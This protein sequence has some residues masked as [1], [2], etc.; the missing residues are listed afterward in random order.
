MKVERA[1]GDTIVS[2]PT[3]LVA[4][5]RVAAQYTI[6]LKLYLLIL[7]A[8]LI[9]AGSALA[10]ETLTVVDGKG[11][12]LILRGDQWADLA[13]GE[14]VPEGVPI[15]TLHGA[16]ITLSHAGQLLTL[17]PDSAARLD[18]GSRRSTVLTQFAGTLTI[19]A[20]LPRGNQLLVRAPS[21]TVDV[22]PGAARLV[23]IADPGKVEVAAGSAIVAD[24]TTRVR[25][26][27]AAGEAVRLAD[28]EA[29]AAAMLPADG[30]GDAPSPV[31]GIETGTIR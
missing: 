24:P 17:A 25:T 28:M 7:V 21:L 4:A 8:A 14:E 6:R 2:Q 23:I 5:A 3:A 1:H 9:A 29:A 20:K 10:A 18:S 26:T 27:V 22:Q 30:S 15:R 11:P 13:A 16:T 31:D 19:E 12:A